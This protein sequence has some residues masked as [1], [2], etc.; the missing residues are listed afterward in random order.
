M[1]VRT[2][3]KPLK[4]TLKKCISCSDLDDFVT[5]AYKRPYTFQQQDGCK[6]RGVETV[7]VP[8]IHPHDYPNATVPEKING[9]EMGV[10]FAAWLARDPKTWNGPKKDAPDISMFWERNFY[11]SLD[12]V[13]NDLHA[14]GLIEAGDYTIE[15]DW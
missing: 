7:T 12:M 13:L 8:A 4:I 2:M 5:Q 15:I 6:E 9:S 11:P 3:P 1:F 14:K 10:S